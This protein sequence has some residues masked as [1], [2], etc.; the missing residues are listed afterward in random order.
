M[1][2]SAVP[3]SFYFSSSFPIYL[4]YEAAR[5]LQQAVLKPL[6]QPGSRRSFWGKPY[7]YYHYLR[8]FYSDLFFS[9]LF[10]LLR[11]CRWWG[12]SLSAQIYLSKFRKSNV[13]IL[14]ARC[15]SF[16]FHLSVSLFSFLFS[17]VFVFTVFMPAVSLSLFL[18]HLLFFSSV[19]F[20]VNAFFETTIS[21]A[22]PDR[23]RSFFEH[24]NPTG[25][26]LRLHPGQMYR[27][28]ATI[29]HVREFHTKS[30]LFGDR[31]RAPSKC[32]FRCSSSSPLP[33]SFVVIYADYEQSKQKSVPI[34]VC[35]KTQFHWRVYVGPSCHENLAFLTSFSTS[36]PLY[37]VEKGRFSF[38][39]VLLFSIPLYIY[40]SLY[41]VS[42]FRFS[43]C[44]LK[45]ADRLVSHA[46]SA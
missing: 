2:L 37:R 16:C 38:Y 15:Y 28:T 35:K 42:V 12:L 41:V 44:S 3:S 34:L 8:Y 40:V 14:R 5:E 19:N 24:R 36:R 43:W 6:Q 45:G 21:W 17:C 23:R 13:R 29:C 9:F 18:Y 20:F 22:L 25:S 4:T 32:R 26:I 27:V 10:F 30:F 11:G 46:V 33:T 39:T 7:I 31:R 1:L